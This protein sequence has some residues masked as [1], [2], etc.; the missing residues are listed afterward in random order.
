MQTASA[1]AVSFLKIIDIDVKVDGDK[2]SGIGTGGG[3]IDNVEPGN[4]IEIKI[5]VQ[6]VY[7][8]G[9]AD[10]EITDIE[11][12][13][14]DIEDIDDGDDLEPDDEPDDFDLDDPGDKKTITLEY[15]V[16]IRVDE[17][18]FDLTVEIEGVNSTGAKMN[19]S[20]DFTI[21]IDKENHLLSI[22]RLSLENE[23]VKCGRS[24]DLSFLVFNIGGEDEEDV[25]IRIV[26]DELEFSVSE[27]LDLDEGGEDD[28]TE[29]GSNYRVNVPKNTP[30]GTYSIVATVDYRNGRESE[31]ET[32]DLIVDC[33]PAAAPTP[34]PT[35]KPKP[36]T[37]VVTQPT[38]TNTVTQPA[39][40]QT[41][42]VPATTQGSF[43]PTA[44][45][46]DSGLGLII[47]AYVAGIA[48]LI[49]LIIFIV[50]RRQ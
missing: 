48:I 23:Q 1:T 18:T 14:A 5:K 42:T 19:V 4:K 6:N 41:V 16:P 49:V 30:S 25:E 45:Q 31:R 9:S 46:S 12:D 35:P 10:P 7:P 34:T 28:D 27:I 17:D 43:K 3:S 20:A 38:P 32:V 40:P 37:T 24:T 22:E 29:F 26:N 50:R 47:A 39:T 2:E 8:S 33:E 36:T 44:K 13:Q 11:V 15:K 21:E